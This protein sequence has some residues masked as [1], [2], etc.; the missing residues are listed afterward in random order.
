LIVVE[1]EDLWEDEQPQLV[2]TF[3]ARER[4][5]ALTMPATERRERSRVFESMVAGSCGG[6]LRSRGFGLVERC[7]RKSVV[8]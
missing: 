7:G 6:E 8:K 1:V 5:F 3:R 2:D 4:P